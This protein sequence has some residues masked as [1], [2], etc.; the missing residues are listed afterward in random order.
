MS[1]RLS[2]VGVLVGLVLASVV[3]AGEGDPWLWLEEIDGERPLEW[4]AQQNRRTTSALEAVPEYGPVYE[5]SL[6][7]LDSEDRIPY[8]AVLGSY[9]YN[10]WQDSE[11]ERG[12]WRRTTLDSYRTAEPRWEVLLDLDELAEREGVPWVSRGANCLPPEYARCVVSLSRGGSDAVTLR[13]FDTVARAFVPDGFV[14]PEAKTFFAWKDADTLWIATDFGEGTLTTSG[15]PRQVREWRRGTPLEEARVIFEGS[16][17]DVLVAGEALHA[18]DGRY[19]VIVRVK[20]FF[21]TESYLV[22]GGRLVRLDLPNDAQG[23]GIFRDHLLLSLRSDWTV[24]DTV[25]PQGALLAMGLDGLLRGEPSAEVLFM[26]TETVFLEDVATTRDR[27]LMTTLDHV[28]GRLYAISLDSGA[29]TREE[30]A[31]PGLGTVGVGAWPF[32]EAF[33]Y[34]YQDFVTPSS[35]FLVE[36]GRAKRVKAQPALFDAEGVSVIQLHAVSADGTRIPYFLVTP[37]GFEPDGTTPT[38]LTGYGGFEVNMLPTYGAVTG[39]AWLERGGA[40]VLANLRGGGEFGPAWHQAAVRENRMRWFEDFIAVADDLVARKLTSRG[41]LGIVGGSNSGLLV[42]GAFTLRPGL[43]R[44]VVC[45][46]PLLDMKRYHKLL[47]GASWMSEYGN[48]DV[49]EDWAF[50][51][52]WSPYQLVRKDVDYPTVLFWT[53]HRDDRVHPG[54]GRKMAAKMLAQGHSVYY[55]E[56]L[57]GGHGAGSINRQRAELTALEYAFLWKTLR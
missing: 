34:S 36:E 10:F 26:P 18:P 9:A 54:H 16:P 5:R 23:H 31:L 8:P 3:G 44:A 13:E 51:K 50:M 6:A 47:A 42:G 48:P 4:V 52:E 41:H 37:E 14:A 22:L 28:K 7:I 12:V 53:N 29:W 1:R 19:D 49:P 39:A 56:H 32:S 27:V 46:V 11:H 43:C 2:W 38:I 55:F 45:Q 21:D 30:I 40:F 35:L 17:D 25:Y 20:T 15:Y 57:E 24:G 33:T